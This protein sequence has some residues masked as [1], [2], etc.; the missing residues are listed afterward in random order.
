EGRLADANRSEIPDGRGGGDDLHSGQ[1]LELAYLHDRLALRVGDRDVGCDLA[2]REGLED[3]RA[4]ELVSSGGEG[5]A[6]RLESAGGQL[7]ED[8]RLVLCAAL[9]EHGSAGREAIDDDERERSGERQ[10]RRRQRQEDL[11]PEREAAPPRL[12]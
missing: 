1:R 8:A 10:G 11:Q 12:D 6:G 9:R 4:L 7:G 3:A 5:R 2:V